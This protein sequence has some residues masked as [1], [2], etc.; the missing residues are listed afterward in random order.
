VNNK[1]SKGHADP[2]LNAVVWLAIE[3]VFGCRKT[4]RLL[5]RSVLTDEQWKEIARRY[6]E[7]H[8]LQKFLKAFRRR[9]YSVAMAENIFVHTLNLID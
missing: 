8:N 9:L 3:Q 7:K 2:V 4:L 1:P 6:V 5:Q